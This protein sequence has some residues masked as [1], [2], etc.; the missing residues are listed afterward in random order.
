MEIPLVFLRDANWSPDFPTTA[1]LAHSLYAQ[2]AGVQVDGIATVDLRAVQLLVGALGPLTVEGA[3]APVTG[4]NIIEQVQRFWD[5]PPDSDDTLESAGGEWWKQRKDFMPILAKAALGRLESGRFNPLAFAAALRTAL[6]ERAIQVWMADAGAAE[7]LA[8]L[9]WDGSLQPEPG[10]DFVALVDSNMGY[11]KV[12]AVLARSLRYAVTWPD[13]PAQPAQATLSATYRHPL[14]VAGHVCDSRSKYGATYSDMIER[15]Y[16]DYVR[17][18]VPLG[19][20]LVSITGVEADSINS[21]P[22]ERGTQ[23]FAG[24]FSVAPGS[25][26]TVTFIYRLPPQ[27]TPD[28]Y[29]LVIQRQSGTGPL[30][31]EV[32][33]GAAELSTT[34]AAGRLVW[35]PAQE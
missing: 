27:I 8:A 23:V 2:D 12:D 18:Y 17:L 3:D 21:Q 13:G 15:C 10:A 29:R 11:N 14:R 9:H 33:A 31:V 16:F 26:H 4:E 1:Q 6:D 7:L 20:E 32:K 25:E 22:G 34:L 5:K 19:S 30:P 28:S 35:A 24:Y